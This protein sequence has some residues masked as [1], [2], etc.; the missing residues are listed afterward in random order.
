MVLRSIGLTAE[1]P[2]PLIFIIILIVKIL[3]FIKL[4]PFSRRNT[5]KEKKII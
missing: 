5:I 3:I 1:L 2:A 4:L